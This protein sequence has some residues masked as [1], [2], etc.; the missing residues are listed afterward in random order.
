[1]TVLRACY[2][3]QKLILTDESSFL[4]KRGGWGRKRFVYHFVLW[5]YL[6]TLGSWQPAL[7]RTHKR[8][9]GGRKSSS[10]QIC[11]YLFWNPASLLP[12]S[13]PVNHPISQYAQMTRAQNEMTSSFK[14]QRKV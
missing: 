14:G 4:K 10:F 2:H 1:M 6:L 8:L 5:C 11:A 12:F 9:P 3:S 7:V 13:C